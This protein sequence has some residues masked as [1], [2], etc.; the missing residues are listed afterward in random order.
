MIQKIRSLCEDIFCHVYKKIKPRYIAEVSVC[1]CLALSIVIVGGF[2]IDSQSKVIYSLDKRN[3]NKEIIHLINDADKY[4]Y[5]AIYYFTKADIA[6]ALVR[7]KDRGVVVWGITDREA[8]TQSNKNIVEKLRSH[9]ITVETQK[10]YDGIMHI[11]A[12]VTD[13]AYASGSYNWTVAAT[14][15]NDEV[16]EVG[17]NEHKRKEYLAIVK[18]VLIANQ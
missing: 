8:S 12:I 7:A 6:D 3:I 18:K 15:A 2:Y 17:T 16:L 1:L 4:I 14:E 5:F 9:G 10:H 11:K 13:K